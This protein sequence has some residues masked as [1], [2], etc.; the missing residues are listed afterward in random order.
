M[1][2]TA[3]PLTFGSWLGNRKY[4]PYGLRKVEAI[5]GGTVVRPGKVSKYRNTVVGIYVN[6][7]L[8]QTEIGKAISTILQRDPPYVES[9]R[10]FE[11]QMR[12]LKTENSLK[13]IVGGPG[14]WQLTD[15]DWIDAILIGEAEESLKEAIE[16]RGVVYGK[17]AEHFT[18]IRA[19]SGLA[20]VEVNRGSRKIP[21][22]VILREM[23]IQG[24]AHGKVNLI[25]QDILSYGDEGEVLQL[26]STARRY[27]D[28]T[29]S[30]INAITALNF[31]LEKVRN[32]LGLGENRHISPV[33]NSSQGSCVYALDSQVLKEL[34]RNFIYPI[35]YVGEEE[36]Q[37]FLDFKAII[38]P[39]PQTERY[40]E[41][42]YK[43]WL[44][45]KK[46][47]KIP[48]SFVVDYVLKKALETKGEHLRKLNKTG[49]I[50]DLVSASF[51]RLFQPFP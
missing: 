51:H 17:K 44:H 34:N 16:G 1:I 4:P 12:R 27:G 24:S 22:S 6:D 7:P 42:L 33:L 2:L 18:P 23:E 8:G 31:D 30:N 10:K 19:P 39:L 25:T 11:I 50:K 20:E 36:V 14:A 29:F 41:V 40:Y 28:V 43:V 3:D 35:I 49:L 46:Y 5:S 26:L 15:R 47:V 48:F 9:F 37:Q 21:W 13:V 45:D 32:V 38:I